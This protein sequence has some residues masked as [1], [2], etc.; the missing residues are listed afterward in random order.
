MPVPDEAGRRHIL[1]IHTK[2][3]PLAKDVD[4]DAL[5][6]RSDRFT[7]ADLEDLVRRAGLFALR[8]SL[9]ASEVTMAE[10]EQALV[11][12]RASVTPEMERDY[13]KIQENLKQ[14]AR[15]AGGGIGFIAPGMLTPRGPKG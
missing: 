6:E 3:M 2:G 11:E 10:F 8:G 14:E 1:G 5:A 15:S 13:E 7:G 9:E 12:T 4:L